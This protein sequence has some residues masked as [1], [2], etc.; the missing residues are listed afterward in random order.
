MAL[1][2]VDTTAPELET[3]ID[4]AKVY[5]LIYGQAVAGNVP[6]L[7]ADWANGIVGNNAYLDCGSRSTTSRPGQGHHRRL[8]L[9]W[10]FIG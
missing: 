7:T 6:Q 1:R 9:H 10:R 2:R 4:N 3:T 8:P 5:R